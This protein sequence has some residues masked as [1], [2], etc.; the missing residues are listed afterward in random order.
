M[1]G[2]L[3]YSSAS[4]S[5]L[6][7]SRFLNNGINS[8]KHRG[9]DSKGIWTNKD[10]SV[11]MAHSRLSIIDLSNRSNQPMVSDDLV[12]VFNGEIYNYLELKNELKSLGIDFATNSDTEVILKGFKQWNKEIF[13][14]LRGMFSIAIF[15]SAKNE[16]ILARDHSGQKP[17]YYFFDKE[18]GT[19]IFASEIKAILCYKKFNREISPIGLNRLFLKGFCEEPLSIYK[20]I[21]KLEAGKYL[22]F[23]NDSKKKSIE[24]FWAIEDHVYKAN[25]EFQSEDALLKTLEEL[26]IE[27]IDMQFRSDVPV[28]MLLSG[29]V[30]S[31]LIVSL[32]SKIKN[33]LDT[34]TVRFSGY[35][36]FDES[37]HARL[38]AD[39][40]RT[41]HFELEASKL[42]PNILDELINFYDE[43]IFDTSTIP[44]FLLSKLIS[45]HCKVAIGG[46]GGDELFGGYPHYDKLLRIEHNTKFIP[47]FLRS[48]SADILIS[49]LNIGIRG[50][51]TAEFIGNNYNS[52]YPNTSEFF[53]KRQQS[54]LFKI[55]FLKQIEANATPGLKPTIYE[56]LIDTATVYDF[57]KFLREDILVKVDRASMAHSLEI[58]SP[59]LDHKI[60]EFVFSNIP[61]RLKVTKNERK[62]LLKKLAQKH[63]PNNF[64]FQRKQG[65]SIPLRQLIASKSWNDYFHSKIDQS[66]PKIFNHSYAHSLLK[67]Q[68]SYH[69]N[70]ERMSA[71]IFF[72]MW[73]EKFNPS[74]PMS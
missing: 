8:L 32:A 50:S 69:N 58:R 2:I 49:L 47:H 48:A 16:F 59:F 10:H 35:K 18:E 42:D 13:R 51:K 44:T 52:E 43:P 3:G 74:F 15:D 54:K 46:D 53:S 19:F 31:S 67:A 28:G 27:S 68:N 63:L 29:G 14:K 71:L 40:F 33:N 12:I 23:Q 11:G 39:T 26:L 9:P 25:S 55:D 5:Y 41:N 65:F 21:N 73:V 34:F 56:N 22:T 1:C 24:A 7:S 37:S 36:E 38:I 4:F 57:K 20:K 45:K 6:D 66:D 72:M 17:L 70:A 61:S 64:D 30:D 62:I 60:I